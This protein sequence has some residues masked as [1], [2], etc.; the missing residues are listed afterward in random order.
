M[1]GGEERL[2]ARPLFAFRQALQG[3]PHSPLSC[4][5]RVAR[6]EMWS[7]H[8]EPR[9]PR[10]AQTSLGP[11]IACTI[12]SH[13]RPGVAFWGGIVLLLFSTERRGCCCCFHALFHLRLVTP[14]FRV[15]FFHLVESRLRELPD[16]TRSFF[17]FFKLRDTIPR[18]PFLTRLHYFLFQSLSKKRQP[19]HSFFGHFHYI[20]TYLSLGTLST[21][22]GLERN[23][24][25]PRFVSPP[26]EIATNRCSS[27]LAVPPRGRPGTSN[28][29]RRLES[30]SGKQQ[31][32][33]Y[34][35]TLLLGYTTPGFRTLIGIETDGDIAW[36]QR[37]HRH[38]RRATCELVP[39]GSVADRLATRGCACIS[40]YGGLFR[41]LT[42]RLSFRAWVVPLHIASP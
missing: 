5:L 10:S 21:C 1:D 28:Q 32:V 19:G 39:S 33:L 30:P 4:S 13:F 7:I 16:S 31:V 25:L 22:L 26:S 38:R 14:P 34:L 17:P 15:L 24:E 18:F 20:Y 36:N 6:V 37:R 9:P 23:S 3:I 27:H 35:I 40:C 12:Q 8:T 11:C 41:A 2:Q 42:V 29:N